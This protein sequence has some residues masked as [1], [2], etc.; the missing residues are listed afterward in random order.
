MVRLYKAINLI[1]IPFLHPLAVL[2]FIAGRVY[3]ALRAGF[4]DGL[5]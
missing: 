4:Q 2:G 1:F 3:S 5:L